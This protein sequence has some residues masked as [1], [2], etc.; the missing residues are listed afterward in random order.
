MLL[1]MIYTSPSN[2]ISEELKKIV[3]MGI[4]SAVEEVSKV[5]EENWTDFFS[6]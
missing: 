5:S 3:N 6:L 2:Q 1:K 4:K